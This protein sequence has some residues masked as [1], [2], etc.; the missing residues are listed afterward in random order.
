MRL[1][2]TLTV[3]L[4]GRSAVGKSTIATALARRY[5]VTVRHCGEI[6]KQKAKDLGCWI[7]DLAAQIHD[8]IDGETRQI[9]STPRDSWMLI[10]G[11]YLDLVLGDTQNVFLI[12][13]SCNE[14]VRAS[15]RGVDVKAIVEEDIGD[16]EFR[17]RLSARLNQ[18][19]AALVIDTSGL[20]EQ[21][22]EEAIVGK[23]DEAVNAL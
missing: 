13:L 7:G 15:R 20:T 10:E 19:G 9:A 4:F 18:R 22:T 23:L 11:R 16:S 14:S 17:A 2:E 3:A 6:A 12:E 5:G 8:E 21:E 1:P